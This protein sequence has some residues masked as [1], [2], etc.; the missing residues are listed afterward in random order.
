[1]GGSCP[2]RPG[3]KLCPE[4]PPRYK[5]S[6]KSTGVGAG[7]PGS[8][9][10]PCLVG[11]TPGGPQ[12]KG[13]QEPRVSTMVRLEALLSRDPTP[14]RRRSGTAL[15]TLQSPGGTPGGP[16]VGEGRDT[17]LPGGVSCPSPRDRVAR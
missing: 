9:D 14:G 8:R 4:R 6:Q 2:R 7:Q 16:R 15:L 17:F 3:G 10:D 11:V 5:E 13:L 1:M 12:W